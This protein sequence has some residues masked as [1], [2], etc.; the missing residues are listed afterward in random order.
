M[1]ISSTDSPDLSE[2]KYLALFQYITGIAPGIVD[3]ILGRGPKG[4]IAVAREVRHNII[5]PLPPM[6]LKYQCRCSARGWPFRRARCGYPRH[7]EGHTDLGPL[8]S[9]DPA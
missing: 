2:R 3:D 9:P 5:S 6:V 7:Q 4:T 1:I 8:R